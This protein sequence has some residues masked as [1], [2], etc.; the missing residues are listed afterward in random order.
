MVSSAAAKF[1]RKIVYSNDQ[2]DNGKNST[3]TGA[4]IGGILGACSILAISA[5]LIV[6]KLRSKGI[7]KESNNYDNGNTNHA[8]FSK[9]IGQDSNSISDITN[10]ITTSNQTYGIGE[11]STVVYAVVNKLKK[12]ENI[13]ETYIDAADGEYDHLHD[14]QNRRIVPQENVYHSHEVSRNKDDLT[15]DSSN[16]ANGKFNKGNNIYDQSFSMSKEIIHMCQIIIDNRNNTT[17][18]W[19]KHL[20][21]VCLALELQKYPHGVT[22]IDANDKCGPAGLENDPLVLTKI[23]EL[24]GREFWIGL[25]IYTQLTPWI[26]TLGCFLLNM[27]PSNERFVSS[28]GLCQQECSTGYFSYN[29]TN[30]ANLSSCLTTANTVLV[31]EIYNGTTIT[32]GAKNGLC[33]T[34]TCVPP[35]AVDV[36]ASLC[37][38]GDYNI[39][40]LCEDGMQPTSTASW[41]L[42]QNQISED[43]WNK[44]KLLLHS[45]ACQYFGHTLLARAWTNVF[46]EEKEVERPLGFIV[47]GS[48]GAVIVLLIGVTVIL[49]KV[50]RIGLFKSNASAK[51]TNV[52]F[53]VNG[54]ET[55]L[56]VQTQQHVNKGIGLVYQA[57]EKSNKTNNSYAQV[58]KVK[59][60]EDS[61][62]ENKNGEYDHLH[63][64]GGRKPKAGENT[65]DSN[66]GVRNR[67]DPTYDTATSSSGLDMDNTYD[68]SFSNMKSYSEYDVSDSCMEID[69]TNYD[70]YDQAC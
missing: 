13:Q 20:N 4:V 38:G 50:R 11:T 36:E 40:S 47:V 33:T 25:G 52:V 44:D 51:T 8:H 19:T 68:H 34:L 59:R 70:V 28:A 55:S 60:M 6:C 48:V 9:T 41:G 49:C 17:T 14:I 5:V 37:E 16:F 56:E 3:S 22:A 64:I 39:N 31:Y 61:Y 32:S 57:K 10:A 63:N 42:S 67:N 29:L 30:S 12:P 21:K 69:R 54:E 43:C 2:T 45:N 65:Y 1:K 7:F 53:S 27:K 23:S 66:V 26:E 15:Y 58:Q 46:R 62:T 35:H 24:D 18:I